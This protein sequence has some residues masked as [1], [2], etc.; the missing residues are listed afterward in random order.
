MN[1]KFK[2]MMN[3][4]YWSD[5]EEMEI[6]IDGDFDMIIVELVYE[7]EGDEGFFEMTDSEDSDS[8]LEEGFIY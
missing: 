4:I 1:M 6:E 5:G 8:D 2:K 3:E 7:D